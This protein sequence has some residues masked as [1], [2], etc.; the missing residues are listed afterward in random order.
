MKRDLTNL[1]REGRVFL[2]M[3]LQAYVKDMINDGD[4]EKANCDWL[5]VI[6]MARS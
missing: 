4:Y 1:S 6:R 2:N 5:S 3:T